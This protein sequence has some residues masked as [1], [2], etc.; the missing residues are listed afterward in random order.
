MR[1]QRS[2]GLALAVAWGCGPAVVKA[3]DDSGGQGPPVETGEGEGE[4]EGEGD[5][6]AAPL[7]YVNE[8]MADNQATVAD[9]TGAYPDWIELYNPGASAVDLEGWTITDTLD[10][11][12]RHTLG[13]VSVAAGGHQL[14]WAD[15]H[16]DLGALHLGFSLD[17]DGEAVGLFDAAGGPVDGLRFGEQSSDISLARQP[18]AG[19][20]WALDTTPTP[21]E[22]NGGGS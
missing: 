15:G 12:G 21:G 3:P 1:L 9:E 14:L 13:A 16:A 6:S 11:P 22:D 2:R 19:Q 4:G 7:L 20:T 8:V 5:T 10:E 17:E 18:D